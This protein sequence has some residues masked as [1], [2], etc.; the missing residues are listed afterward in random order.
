M[1]RE[2]TFCRSWLWWCNNSRLFAALT[3]ALSSAIVDCQR[4]AAIDPYDAHECVRKLYTWQNVAQRT[5]RVYDFVSRVGE[6]SLVS[7]LYRYVLL[8]I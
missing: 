5:E 1:G 2:G 8:S 4:G 7:R 3:D 6:P